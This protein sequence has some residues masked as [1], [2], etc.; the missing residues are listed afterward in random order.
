MQHLI[1][2]SEAR[3]Q[4]LPQV[5]Y[6]QLEP[7]EEARFLILLRGPHEEMIN[8]PENPWGPDAKESAPG[9]SGAQER[10]LLAGL[11]GAASPAQQGC[12]TEP[13]QRLCVERSLP[14]P[15]FLFKVKLPPC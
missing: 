13:G 2:L 15:I 5:N 10:F 6:I 12:F 3:L 1:S 14:L 7:L 8:M 4:Q 11:P 9:R